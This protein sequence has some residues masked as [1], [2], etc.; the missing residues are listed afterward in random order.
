MDTQPI[1][2]R[3]FGNTRP[4]VR[5]MIPRHCHQIVDVGC[6]AGSLGAA[7]KEEGPYR[8]VRGIEPI[9]KVA[10]I[11]ERVLDAVQRGTADDG[12]P[13]DW[14]QPDC[15]IFADVLE[16]MPDPWTTLS[17]WSSQLAPGTCFV[18]SVPNIG[19]FSVIIGLLRGRFDYAESGPLDRTHLRFFT[20]KSTD[21]LVRQA[22]LVIEETRRVL[23]YPLGR[24][25]RRALGPFIT[26]AINRE[27]R[28][29]PVARP[30]RWL[31]DIITFQVLVRARSSD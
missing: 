7:L 1:D 29:R 23:V 10:S 12:P 3:Y 27:G 6:G 19:H 21:D 25:G 2:L 31:L 14:P 30:L 24:I 26:I 28:G 16:H 18:F 9:E 5:A 4:E 11:A 8:E 20:P 15:V 13:S 17:K 22:G